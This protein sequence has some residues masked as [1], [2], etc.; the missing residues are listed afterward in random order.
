MS[1]SFDLPLQ[2]DSIMTYS[3]SG[4]L[5]MILGTV[6]LS[7]ATCALGNDGA[8]AAPAETKIVEISRFQFQPQELT[9]SLGTAIVWLN[10]DQTVHNVVTRDGTVAS[11][12]LDTD[13]RYTAVFEHEGDYPYYCALHPQMVG[14]VHVRR[15]QPT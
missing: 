13:D 3:R 9:V 10:R 1:R 15:R 14:I 4:S 7:A 5:S 8:R 6:L 12:G 11:P 2:Q